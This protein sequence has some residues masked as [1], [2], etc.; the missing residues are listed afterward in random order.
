[1]MPFVNTLLMGGCPFE[2]PE[3]SQ[4]MTCTSYSLLGLRQY[5]GGKYSKELGRFGIC[6]IDISDDVPT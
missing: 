4:L 1:M 6:E 5:I 3:A 2:F